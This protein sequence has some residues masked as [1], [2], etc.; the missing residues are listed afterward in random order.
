MDKKKREL[1]LHILKNGKEFNT[2]DLDTFLNITGF[3]LK[4]YNDQHWDVLINA[5]KILCPLNV[6]K[7]IIEKGKYEGKLDYYV[8]ENDNNNSESNVMIPLFLAI[9]TEQ[10]KVADLLLEKGAHL[11]YTAHYNDNKIFLLKYLYRYESINKQ[12]LRYLK[13]HDYSLNMDNMNPFIS[14][15]VHEIEDNIPLKIIME[16]FFFDNATI[17]KLLQCYKKREPMSRKRL[18]STVYKNNIQMENYYYD[19]LIRKENI[20]LLETLLDYSFCD[21]KLIVALKKKKLLELALDKSSVPV[22]KK[23]LE[24]IFTNYH[25][26]EIEKV[27]SEIIPFSMKNKKISVLIEGMKLALKIIIK[28]LK[29]RSIPYTLFEKILLV[30]SE[31][32]LLEIMEFLLE[33]LLNGDSGKNENVS[34]FFNNDSRFLSLLL[35]IAIKVHSMKWVKHL[36]EQLELK[37]TVYLN[38]KDRNNEYPILVAVNQVTQYNDYTAIFDYLEE[39]GADITVKDIFGTSL[40]LI[41]L[42]Q[43]KYKVI[44]KLIQKG[45]TID[46]NSDKNYSLLVKAI[47]KNDIDAVT[48]IV[49]KKKNKNSSYEEQP[50]SKRICCRYDN[51]EFTPLVMAYLL[52][53]HDIFNQLLESNEI[54]IDELDSNGCSLLHYVILREDQ[55]T[56]SLLIKRGVRMEYRENYGGIGHYLLDLVLSV[57]RKDILIT[58]LKHDTSKKLIKETNEFKE[59]PLF[60]LIKINIESLHD[61]NFKTDIFKYLVEQGLS[62][63]VT[64]RDDRALLYCVLDLAAT[65]EENAISL[66]QYMIKRGINIKR[67]FDEQH[68]SPVINAIKKGSIKVLKLLLDHGARYQN[69]TIHEEYEDDIICPFFY[70]IENGDIRINQFLV[71]YFKKKGKMIVDLRKDLNIIQLFHCLEHNT[72]NR[73]EVLDYLLQDLLDVK[74]LELDVVGSLMDYDNPEKSFDVLFRHGFNPNLT[75]DDGDNLLIYALKTSN[76]AMSNYFINHGVD[77]SLISKDEDCLRF[78]IQINRLDVLKKLIEQDSTLSLEKLLIYALKCGNTRIIHYLLKNKNLLLKND[79]SKNTHNMIPHENEMDQS[80][81]YQ[82]VKMLKESYLEKS[83]N[84]DD[85]NK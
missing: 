70:T 2:N 24:C 84:E 17:L 60:T 75:D 80:D 19:V 41:A 40:F 6:I 53:R 73:A 48:S 8:I 29:K 52:Q 77:I 57:G 39:Q 64:G 12:T 59:S 31:F 3:Q 54:D 49:S 5:I 10:F 74:Q 72:R 45:Y 1:L 4:E 32:N 7:Y 23:G 22:T 27:F 46:Y 37:P 43:K 36:L 69:Y 81:F 68:L 33:E 20:D 25:K 66:L 15:L 62:M 71:D 85:E 28:S 44:N 76:E 11:N 35:N 34:E 14:I 38:A 55:E 9:L 56:L 67:T 65:E 58:L 47:Y 79:N 51:Y 30:I 13:N 61:Q 82:Y 78:I 83:L 50:T 26:N 16:T 18:N 42:R 21:Y 63:K